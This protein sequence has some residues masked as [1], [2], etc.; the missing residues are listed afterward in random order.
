[1]E[2]LVVTDVAREV[3]AIR[4]AS[5]LQHGSFPMPSLQVLDIGAPS[6]QPRGIRACKSVC[7][8]GSHKGS[9]AIALEGYWCRTH[10]PALFGGSHI[11]LKGS[12][13]RARQLIERKRDPEVLE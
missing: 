13:D 9:R 12:K 8:W 5:R 4:I 11:N 10:E 7:L 1:M 2:S 6:H 3:F